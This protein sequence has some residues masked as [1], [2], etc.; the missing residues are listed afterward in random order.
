M[1][2]VGSR[3]EMDPVQFK[4]RCK[5]TRVYRGEMY[6]RA[7][8][9]GLLSR[10]MPSTFTQH[11]TLTIPKVFFH[12]GG[13]SCSHASVFIAGVVPLNLSFTDLLSVIRFDFQL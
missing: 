2:F 6:T 13:I 1:V 9:Q 5:Q 10:V 7:A 3:F 4:K 11:Y 12:Y 8:V